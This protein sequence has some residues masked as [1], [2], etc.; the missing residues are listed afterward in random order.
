MVT[1]RWS[2]ITTVAAL[3]MSALISPMFMK[4]PMAVPLDDT[5]ARSQEV[6]RSRIARLN[7]EDYNWLC[8]ERVSGAPLEETFHLFDDVSLRVEED[9]VASEDDNLSH[10]KSTVWTGHLAGQLNNE[11]TLSAVGL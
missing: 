7:L 2:W 9:S 3:T 6:V 4:H 8:D 10:E 11:V 5:E 1:F